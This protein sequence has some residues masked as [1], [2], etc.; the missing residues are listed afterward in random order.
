M[1]SS[2]V[3]ARVRATAALVLAPLFALSAGAALAQDATSKD[4]P[5]KPGLT[6]APVLLVEPEVETSLEI[7]V[8]PD[9]ALPRQSF[10]RVRGLPLSAKLSEGHQIAPG[11]WAI[12]LAAL[13]TLKL[14]A[15]VSAMQSSGT[16]PERNQRRVRRSD[17]RGMCENDDH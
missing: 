9:A 8:G 4:P 11:S 13:A 2:K 16:C 6:L 17:R 3:R 10:V 7:R 14:M 15:P 1:S 5:V 12:P